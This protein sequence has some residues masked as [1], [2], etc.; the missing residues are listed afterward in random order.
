V[1]ALAAKIGGYTVPRSAFSIYTFPD[2]GDPTV[3]AV[4]TITD[5]L[6]LTQEADTKRYEDLYDR[7]LE[8]ALP[9]RES[10]AFLVEAA[11]RL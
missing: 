7:L 3:V 10:L 9:G 6:L 4:D 8:A 1:L 5:D 2:S 11:G